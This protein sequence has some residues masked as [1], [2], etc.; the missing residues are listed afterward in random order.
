MSAA[1]T[2]EHEA[3][4]QARRDGIGWFRGIATGLAIVVVGLLVSVGGTNELLTNVSGM[5]RD[6]LAYLATGLFLVVVMVAA[7]VLRRLQSRGII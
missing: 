1:G 4:A 3:D 2:G 7:W 5:S 6:S